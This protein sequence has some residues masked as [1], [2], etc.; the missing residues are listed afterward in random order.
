MTEIKKMTD[1]GNAERLIEYNIDSIKYCRKTRAW[2]IWR[3]KKWHIDDGHLLNRLAMQ[4]IDKIIDEAHAIENNPSL[5]QAML[6]HVIK[7]QSLTRV[8]AMIA[9]A[10]SD[11]RIQIDVTDLD[12]DPMKLNLSN[13]TLDLR[14]KE[15]TEHFRKDMITKISPV[16]YDLHA[17]CPLFFR[18]IDRITDG[19]IAL[20]NYIKK[21]AGYCLT[22]ITDEQVIF[23]F[24]GDGANGKS[25][26]LEIMRKILGN[27]ARH[28]QSSSFLAGSKAIRNDIA[29]LNG[30]RFVSAVEMGNNSTIDEALIKQMT[31]GDPITVRFLY[32]EYFELKP[33][34]KLLIAMNQEPNIRG[35]DH[36][37][38]RRLRIVPFDVT[39]SDDELDRNLLQKLV[40]EMPGILNWMVQGCLEWQ[41][42]G[43][44]VP[45][46]ISLRTQMLK[47]ELDVIGLFLTDCIVPDAEGTITLKL[48]FELYTSW[49]L[50]NAC[51]AMTK[52][53]FGIYMKRKNLTQGKS[54]GV[55][56]WRH[57]SMRQKTTPKPAIQQPANLQ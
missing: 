5:K 40:G 3:E 33:S 47:R 48:M 36:G 9:L 24:I 26:L 53:S 31:G 27:Y 34:F 29:R 35:V 39:I 14:T 21:I 49:C 50:E 57:L 16:S 52:K 11:P 13:G 37:I 54:D 10:Q 22:G 43:I 25:T 6:N 12:S 55:R 19:N 38:W 4:T 17:T 42:E 1:F 20:Q 41:S 8:K 7:S 32:R 23:V 30:A 46:E 2:Y 56:F 51:D 45:S 18:F 15:L 28:V 44:A